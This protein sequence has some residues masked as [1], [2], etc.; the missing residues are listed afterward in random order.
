MFWTKTWK[1]TITVLQLLQWSYL[2]RQCIF[3]ITRVQIHPRITSIDPRNKILADGHWKKWKWDQN[4]RY[5]SKWKSV[6]WAKIELKWWIFKQTWFYKGL[7]R[8]SELL[9]LHHN[10][11]DGYK[12]TT[13]IWGKLHLK[14]E[15]ICNY[16]KKNSEKSTIKVVNSWNFKNWANGSRKHIKKSKN[17]LKFIELELGFFVKVVKVDKKFLICP[18]FSKKR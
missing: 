12:R 7:H 10:H 16:Y 15:R 17:I 4:K 2:Q 18:S 6:F 5:I 8:I 3:E 14:Q 9:R 1:P 11:Y 13:K